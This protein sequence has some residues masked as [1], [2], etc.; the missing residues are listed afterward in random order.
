VLRQTGLF[1]AL[2]DANDTLHNSAVPISRTSDRFWQLQAGRDAGWTRTTAPRLKIGWHPHEIVFVAQ[3]PA[4]YMLVY[5]SGRVAA[6]D[7]P[8][9]ALLASL[10]ESDLTTR[11]REAT[12]GAPRTL[13]GAGALS[14]APPYRRLALWGILVIAVGALAWLAMRMLRE[15]GAA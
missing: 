3:G 4:P 9:D 13:G 14:V 2:R 15:T 11:V 6:S 5:G 10:R 1:Y 8:V 7:A 12:L